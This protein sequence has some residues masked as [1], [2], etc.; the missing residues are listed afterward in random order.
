M[1]LE[2]CRTNGLKVRLFRTDALI[3]YYLYI[4]QII[5]DSIFSWNQQ[6]NCC[7]LP[8]IIVIINEIGSFWV[9]LMCERV[10]AIEYKLAQK[11]QWPVK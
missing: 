11:Y 2:S 8:R 7:L 5:S 10:A 3:S 6:I 4:T 9:C 1:V